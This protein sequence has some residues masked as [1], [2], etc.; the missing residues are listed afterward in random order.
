MTEIAFSKMEGLG[1]DFIVMDDRDGYIEA[2]MPYPQLA[3]KLCDRH[4]GIGGDG[5][6]LVRD[7]VKLDTRFVI[8]NS[9][10]SEAGMCGNGMRCFA[11]YLYEKKIFL[12]KKIRVETAAGT[13]IPEVMVDETNQ[14]T[15]V[16][17]DMGVPVTACSKIPFISDADTAIEEPIDMGEGR[18][19]V[20]T[21]LWVGNPHAVVF[22]KN[23][24]DVDVKTQGRAQEIHPRFPEKTNVEFIEVVDDQ[25]MKM[26]VWERGAGI[27][28]ACGTGACA[29]LAAAH[30]TGRTKNQA[31]VHLDGG[32]LSI[33]WDKQ[34]NHLFK[35]GPARLVFDGRIRI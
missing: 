27:T 1:N 29:A 18:M 7:A 6:I 12:Q 35:T 4:F 34:T 5:I 32:D 22:V 23:L 3:K 15:S 17:V 11:K 8:Y 25:T 16:R 30:L 21:V 26:K 9:D 19:V 2:S 10:G 28:L 20:A 14:V 24:S 33:F 31:I 13:V